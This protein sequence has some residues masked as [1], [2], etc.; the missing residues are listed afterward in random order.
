MYENTERVLTGIPEF[1]RL[2]GG[3]FPKGSIILLAGDP[4]AG[5]TIFSATFL[6][7]GA[8][9][10][11]EPGVYVCFAED[12]ETFLNN[13]SKLGM[14]FKRLMWER[15]I[16]VLDLSIGTEFEVQTI[17][18]K[19]LNSLNSLKAKRLVID[20]I[21]AILVSLKS[22][23]ERR[24]LARLLYKII[25]RVNCT[26]ILIADKP[27]RQNIIGS[28]ILEFVSDGIIIMETYYDA[29]NFLRRRIQILKMRGTGHSLEAHEYVITSSGIKFLLKV[30]EAYQY[31]LKKESIHKI[32]EPLVNEGWQ[33][34]APAK[35]TGRSGLKHEFTLALWNPGN[36][37]KEDSPDVIVDV[38]ISSTEREIN[39]IPILKTFTK[40]FDIRNNNKEIGKYIIAVPSVNSFGKSLSKQFNIKILEANSVKY[41]ESKLR[42][43]ANELIFH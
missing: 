18:N 20:S 21:T 7:K 12:R 6:Y 22:E 14:D 5:K 42:E 29:S 4:G 26:A 32:L 2:V 37:S 24:Y 38:Y 10:F 16:D 35:I 3:G 41:V 8:T 28:E 17:L 19:I 30:E 9:E 11:N 31:V 34:K 15:K 1:D 43:I 33:Y 27:W 25:K 39:E 13:M 40:E 23:V 36:P